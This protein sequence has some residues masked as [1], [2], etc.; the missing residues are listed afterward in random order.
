MPASAVVSVSHREF[1]NLTRLLEIHDTHVLREVRDLGMA[2]VNFYE[3]AKGQSVI[4]IALATG[5][6]MVINVEGATV[7]R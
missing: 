6:S 1:P 5:R 7:A 3:D 2:Q 4:T